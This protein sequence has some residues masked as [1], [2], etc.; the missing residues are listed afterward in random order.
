[1]TG[2]VIVLAAK[3]LREDC[4]ALQEKLANKTQNF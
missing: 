2:I 4:A 3:I 1:M